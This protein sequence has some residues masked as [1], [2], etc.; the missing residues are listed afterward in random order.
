MKYINDISGGQETTTMTITC[1]I[2]MLAHHQDVQNKA[3]IILYF[4]NRYLHYLL[5]NSINLIKLQ[6]FE[7]LQSIFLNGDQNRIPTYKDFQQMKYVEM[8][9]K[10]TLRLFPPIPFLGRRLDEDKQIGEYM[11]PAGN[12]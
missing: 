5:L 3:H 2:F 11:C 1:V 10:E 7:E 6:V 8:V 12:F 9:I 4:T